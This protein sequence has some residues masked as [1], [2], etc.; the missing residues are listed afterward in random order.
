MNCHSKP[1]N[2]YIS[3]LYQVAWLFNRF[4]S[5][6][7]RLLFSGVLGILNSHTGGAMSNADYAQLQVRAMQ[8]SG[9]CRD[10][11]EACESHIQKAKDLCDDIARLREES[12]VL[13]EECIADKCKSLAILK[14]IS[15]HRE[16]VN[17]ADSYAA[18]RSFG[19]DINLVKQMLEEITQISIPEES[20]L[21]K[22]RCKLLGLTYLPG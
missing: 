13:N 15:D 3:R 8:I 2:E 5:R 20:P 4:E 21:H 6:R 18:T 1:I 10:F 7:T 19:D 16:S 22:L 11:I 17:E 9:E 12:A 14:L